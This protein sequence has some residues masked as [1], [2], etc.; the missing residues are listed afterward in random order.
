MKTEVYSWRV[1][2]D[3]KTGLEREAQRRK[4]SVASVLEL[5][6]REW[7]SKSGAGIE[8]VEEQLRLRN[9]ASEC[10][11][12]FA[13]GDPRRSVNVRKAVRERLDRRRDR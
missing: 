3:L 1:S 5:A 12:T 11:G 13:S 10:F 9:A 6:A 7:L 4:T 2:T 8:G